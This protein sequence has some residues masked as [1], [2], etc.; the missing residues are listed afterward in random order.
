[1]IEIIFDDDILYIEHKLEDETYV[2]NV[3]FDLSD[4][5]GDF[6][7]FVLSFIKNKPCRVTIR[8]SKINDN[9]VFFT[10]KSNYLNISYHN[11][12]IKL[13]REKVLDEFKKIVGSLP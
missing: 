3:N 4:D 1:M 13:S 8:D 5:K 7:K 9:D 11:T 2:F 12:N 6:K 10:C